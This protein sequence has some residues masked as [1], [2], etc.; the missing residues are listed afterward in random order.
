MFEISKNKTKQ[1]TAIKTKRQDSLNSISTKKIPPVFMLHSRYY[2]MYYLNTI[3]CTSY[4]DKFEP[5]N[6]HMLLSK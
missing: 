6:L 1:K 2:A 4:Y 3:Y 5:L